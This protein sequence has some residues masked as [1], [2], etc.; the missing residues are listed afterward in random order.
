MGKNKLW[1][2]LTLCPTYNLPGPNQA[3]PDPTH[4]DIFSLLVL[5]NPQIRCLA[6]TLPCLASARPTSRKRDINT[7][8]VDATTPH[9]QHPFRKLWG[10]LG[11]WVMKGLGITRFQAAR[12]GESSRSRNNL[13]VFEELDRV[14]HPPSPGC[15]QVP[16]TSACLLWGV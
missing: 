12:R 4:C 7:A 16:A 10:G 9:L 1:D 6:P 3:R 8:G 5:M 15:V 14:A 2:P 11:I 13:W